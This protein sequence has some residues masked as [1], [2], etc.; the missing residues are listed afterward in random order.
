[1]ITATWFDLA[2]IFGVAVVPCDGSLPR[3]PIAEEAELDRCINHFRTEDL[4]A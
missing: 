1:M 4:W 2:S 3:I